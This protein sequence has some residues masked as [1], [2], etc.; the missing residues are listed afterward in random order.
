MFSNIF[1][2]FGK[3]RILKKEMLENLRD[4][5]RDF[6][7]IYFKEYSNGIIAGTDIH[8]GGN[9]ITVKSGIIKHNGRIYM[10]TGEYEFPYYNTNKEVVI[11][12]K[13]LGDSA[14]GDF[15]THKTKIFIDDV[16]DKS[17]DELELGRF[18]LREGAILRSV[19]TDFYD[20]AT[21]FNTVNIIN[22]EY[23]GYGK[24]T[25]SPDI[26]RYFSRIVLKH[27]SENIYDVS[28]A[29]HCIS[30]NEVTR[31]MILYYIANRL[32][33]DY[34]EYTNLEIYKHLKTIVKEIESG[35]RRVEARPVRPNRIIVD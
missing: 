5:P 18:K 16:I 8:I 19:Y 14:E 30:E 34:K 9:N 28:F 26:L 21:E 22:A 25:L 35:V 17:D 6:F 24:S 12:V 3:G 15:S 33:M 10:L 32:K 23:S 4:Y 31:D 1:P 7:D 11:K 29:M 20:F 2:N 27:S 13:F